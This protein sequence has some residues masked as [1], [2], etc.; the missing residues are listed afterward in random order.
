VTLAEE[1]FMS[2]A[3]S[4]I[5]ASNGMT[6]YTPEGLRLLLGTLEDL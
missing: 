5:T 1:F 4:D 6:P 3:V 2:M